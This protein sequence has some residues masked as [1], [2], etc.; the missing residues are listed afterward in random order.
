[1]LLCC[2]FFN[3]ILFFNS[4]FC[5]KNWATCTCYE[6]WKLLQWWMFWNYFLVIDLMQWGFFTDKI[7]MSSITV[8]SIGG[9]VEATTVE[10]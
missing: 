4:I 5:T 6:L 1:M 3:S 9:K 2:F 7:C 10:P 8:V